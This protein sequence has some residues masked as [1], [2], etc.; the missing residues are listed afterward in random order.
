MQGKDAENSRNS[1]GACCHDINELMF[2]QHDTTQVQWTWKCIFAVCFL[3]CGFWST[4]NQ[5]STYLAIWSCSAWS[6]KLTEL[7][8]SGAMLELSLQTWRVIY[9]V[10]GYGCGWYLLDRFANILSLSCVKEKYC[11]TFDSVSDKL[12]H[13]HKPGK[14]LKFCKSMQCLYHSDVAERDEKFTVLITTINGN[15]SIF[16]A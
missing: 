16:V 5:Q 7:C 11:V 13:V 4:A 12:F 3:R 2:L 6:N 15:K 1:G 9:L 8:T 10:S 14:I